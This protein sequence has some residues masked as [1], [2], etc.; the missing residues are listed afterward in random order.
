MPLSTHMRTLYA[1]AA[2]A[3]SFAAQGA[4]TSYTCEFTLEATPKGLSK[5]PK[6]FELRFVVDTGTKKAYLVG[7][8]GSSEVEIVPN[9]D[10]IS[11]VEITRSGNVMVTPEG[12]VEKQGYVTDI[13]TDLGIEFLEGRPQ[14][15]PFFLMLH[16]KAPHREWTPD[17][18]H[19]AQF[20][21]LV[22]PEPATLRDDYATRPAALPD[23]MQTIARDL[24]RRDL[25]LTPPSDLAPDARNNWLGVKPTEVE[26]AL[27]DSTSKMLSGDELVHWKYERFMQDYLACVQSLDDNVGRILEYLDRTGLAR[28]TVVV[29]TTDNGFFLGDHGLYDKRFM[30]EPSLRVPLVVRWPGVTQAGSMTSRFALN[31]DYAA[32]FLELAGL[33][34]PS[35]I[36]GRSLVPL[37]RGEPP[38]DWRTVVYY[39]YYHDPGDHNTRAHYGIRTATHKLIYYWTKDAWEMFD[40]VVDPNELVNLAGDPAQRE[41]FERL[42]AELLRAKRSAKDDDQFADTE[43]VDGVDGRFDTR[44]ETKPAS[45]R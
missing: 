44:P 12:R 6:P 42:K 16:H 37:L 20:E 19:R 27:A 15:R 33:A 2:L 30:Y 41:T 3:A 23:N 29:Y 26:I 28:N 31:I 10:G 32:T 5:Q 11:F 35:E 39:R 14:D 36:Q 17:E 4:T 9:T 22:I 45:K 38:A 8:A 34:V 43:L 1:T 13:I 21:N 40:L 25:K 7:N 24:T 18:K